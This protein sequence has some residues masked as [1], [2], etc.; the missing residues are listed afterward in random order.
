MNTLSYKV[1]NRIHLTPS[2]Q[3]LILAAAGRTYNTKQLLMQLCVDKRRAQ[4]VL[5]EI[6]I[7]TTYSKCKRLKKVTLHRILR[8]AY[9][10]CHRTHT[11]QW[12]ALSHYVLSFSLVPLSDHA[13]YKIT[14]SCNPASVVQNCIY[15]SSLWLFRSVKERSMSRQA[16]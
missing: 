4:D 1:Y 6:L 2:S 16:E 15:R 10:G 8:T 3:P 7:C 13:V 5:P 14:R 12:N 11:S 9:A